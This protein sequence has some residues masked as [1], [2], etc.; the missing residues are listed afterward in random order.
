MIKYRL[1]YGIEVSLN[2]LQQE[3]FGPIEWSF[4]NT[5]LEFF[6]DEIDRQLNS[7]HGAYG[8]PIFTSSIDIP[9]FVSAIKRLAEWEPVLI[10][11]A[12]LEDMPIAGIP[13]GMIS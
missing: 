11:G 9:D 1:K 5:E 10:E 13:D 6:K 8:H 2:C 4:P 7:M 3:D 12:D